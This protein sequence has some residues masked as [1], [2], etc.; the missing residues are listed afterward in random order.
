MC[1][2]RTGAGGAN[3]RGVRW[4]ASHL[5]PCGANERGVRWADGLSGSELLGALAVVELDHRAGDGLRRGGDEVEQRAVH[6]RWIA[7]ALARE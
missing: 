1:S 6:L 5:A 4:V 2:H 3:E 7:D